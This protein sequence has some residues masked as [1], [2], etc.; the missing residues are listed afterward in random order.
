M[1]AIDAPVRFETAPDIV[2]GIEFAANGRKLAWSIADYLASLERNVGQLLKSESKPDG[3][4][5]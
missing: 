4:N 1:F 3:T 5:P 2:V